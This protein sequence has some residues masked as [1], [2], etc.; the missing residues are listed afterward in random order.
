ME[1]KR[2]AFPRFYF[3]STAD[4]LDIL[5]NGNSPVRVMMHM[6]KCFQVRCDRTGRDTHAFPYSV[7]AQALGGQELA[8]LAASCSAPVRHRPGL[9]PSRPSPPSPHACSLTLSPYPTLRAG[10]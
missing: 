5:S 9:P 1:S 2:R 3:V 8:R 4:L 6:S 7:S 10:H